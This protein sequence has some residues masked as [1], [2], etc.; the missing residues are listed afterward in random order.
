MNEQAGLTHTVQEQVSE[1]APS[2]IGRVRDTVKPVGDG[3]NAARRYLGHLR[4]STVEA[5]AGE[6]TFVGKNVVPTVSRLREAAPHVGLRAAVLATPATSAV[7]APA[8]EL[9]HWDDADRNSHP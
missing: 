2:V 1:K 5:V 3:I 7:E 6:H 9:Q 8:V 4:T